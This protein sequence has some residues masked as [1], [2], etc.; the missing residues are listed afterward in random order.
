MPWSYIKNAKLQ[1]FVKW[2]YLTIV[3]AAAITMSVLII[4]NRKIVSDINKDR[5]AVTYDLCLE[6]NAKNRELI[7]FVQEQV[8]KE[9]KER[10]EPVPETIPIDP[11]ISR[12]INTLAPRQNCEKL[13]ENRFGSKVGE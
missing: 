12:F 11:V 5:K 7:L 2:A 10:S 1:T 4:E 13:V 9:F 6:Q 8:I 3:V